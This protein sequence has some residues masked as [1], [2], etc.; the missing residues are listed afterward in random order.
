[1][2]VK[3]REVQSLLRAF[4]D[5]STPRPRFGVGPPSFIMATSVAA[6]GVSTEANEPLAGVAITLVAVLWF[7]TRFWDQIV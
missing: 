2:S 3:D 5:P 7:Y 1:M 4:R 6:V